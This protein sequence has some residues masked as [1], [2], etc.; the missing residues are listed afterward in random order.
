MQKFRKS[1]PKKQLE[2]HVK[3]KMKL[4][5]YNKKNIPIENYKKITNIDSNNDKTKKIENISS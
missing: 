4:N 3:N 5:I 1:H 2:T